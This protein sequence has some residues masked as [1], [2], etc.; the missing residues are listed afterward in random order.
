MGRSTHQYMAART[1]KTHPKYGLKEKISAYAIGLAT[2][3]SIPATATASASAS[4]LD[5]KPVPAEQLSNENPQNGDTKTVVAASYINELQDEQIQ[6][7]NITW[8][9]APTIS[10]VIDTQT[11]AD[12]SDNAVWDKL[13][14]LESGGNWNT[15]TGNGYYGGLQFS[16]PTWRA[17]G[18]SGLPSDASKEEQI[19]RAKILQAR[20]GWGQW[21][22]CSKALGLI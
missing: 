6:Q 8:A 15:N 19:M 7:S 14:Q 3:A 4:A 12:S 9:Q 17:M 20:S 21:P 16:L 10:K 22:A 1:R 5:S 2:L 11:Q 18:G 13:A